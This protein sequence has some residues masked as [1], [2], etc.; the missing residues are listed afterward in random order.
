M[1]PENG[2]QHKQFENNCEDQINATAT[3]TFHATVL[4]YCEK[5]LSGGCWEHTG[6]YSVNIF[7]IITH[8]EKNSPWL[9]ISPIDLVTQIKERD[10]I[11]KQWLISVWSLPFFL[12]F[13]KLEY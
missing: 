11:S 2:F 4:F 5:G 13:G 10:Y 12:L 3:Y 8:V 6:E 7:N 1:Y 9:T